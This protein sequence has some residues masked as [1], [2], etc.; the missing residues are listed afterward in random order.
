[1]HRKSKI[2]MAVLMMTLLLSGCSSVELEHRNFPLIITLDKINGEYQVELGFENL[3]EVADQNAESK[4]AVPTK[5]TS[6]SWFTAFA[7]NNA[8]N[9]KTMDYNHVKVIVLSKSVLDDK[10]MLKEFLEYIE[11][12]N[13]LARNTLVFSCENDSAEVMELN[14]KLEMPLGTY[15][16]ELIAGQRAVKEKAVVTVGTLL[17]ELYNQQE[18]IYIP[19]VKVEE[20]Q[21]SIEQYYV[22]ANFLSVG[23]VSQELYQEAMLVEGKSAEYQFELDSGEGIVLSNVHVSYQSSETQDGC[24]EQAEIKA[25]AMMQNKSILG[26]SQQQELKK[27]IE[28]YLN[29]TVTAH[30]TELQQEKNLDIS[31]SYYRL[32]GYNRKLYKKYLD[33]PSLYLKDLSYEISFDITPVIE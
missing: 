17:N 8:E 16:E 7:Q 5:N 10:E 26:V 18:N 4:E 27:Q 6:G 33:N 21:A 28:E 20:E 25:D 32:G 1:M 29:A 2:A 30:A 14:G 19:I 23:V 22:L 31:N 15:L 12:Q 11:K 24:L 3:A 9:P 13:I